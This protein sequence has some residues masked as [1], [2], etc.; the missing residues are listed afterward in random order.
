M[1][2]ARRAR[3][4]LL[5]IAVALWGAGCGGAPEPE[6]QEVRSAKPNP[7]VRPAPAEFEDIPAVPG[8]ARIEF[9]E[10][11]IDLGGVTDTGTYEARFHFTNRGAERL[12][13]QKIKTGCKCAQASTA[14]LNYGPGEKGSILV[15]LKPSG[16]KGYLPSV[17]QVVSNS[18]PNELE[19]I[20]LLAT[21]EPMLELESS[22]LQLGQ[23]QPGEEHRV[24]FAMSTRIP[25]LTLPSFH[26]NREFLTLQNIS[27]GQPDE[28]GSRGFTGELVVAA[29]APWGVFSGLRAASASI[30][31]R[32][33][34]KGGA[35]V[36]SGT[37]SFRIE[38]SI[39]REVVPKVLT[40]YGAGSVGSLLYLG[41]LRA[42]ATF[43]RRML[44]RGH[45][46][47]FLIV[48]A[49]LEGPAASLARVIVEANDEDGFEIV[50]AGTAPD[51]RGS[52][53]GD[54]VVTTN[55]PGEETL[56]IGYQGTVIPRR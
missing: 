40:G 54:I 13:I 18:T 29:D 39:Y 43:E 26:T 35:N 1:S 11:T 50:L 2:G 20:S 5:A 8:V 17:V 45:S 30:Q 24:S 55:V 33:T 48:D 32:G 12:V 16:K 9:K 4:S 7:H 3:G 21:V 25:D 44:L 56:R 27:Q 47:P 10:N 38:G 52:L 14:R 34:P 15:T 22:L 42:G 46:A 28:D 23:L 51:R 19:T 37:Y 36:E 49:K 53:R 41:N 6:L 31:V